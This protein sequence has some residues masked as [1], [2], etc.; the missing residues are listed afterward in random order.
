[1]IVTLIAYPFCGI[2]VKT[3]KLFDETIDGNKGVV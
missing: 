3:L 2:G 1:M